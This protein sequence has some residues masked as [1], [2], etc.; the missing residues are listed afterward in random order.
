MAHFQYLAQLGLP[1][2]ITSLVERLIERPV[3]ALVEMLLI[4][5]VVYAVLRFLQG[6]RGARLVRAVLIIL[7]VSFMVVWLIAE[8]FG[9]ERINVLYPYFMLGVFLASLVAFQ[10]ELR[11]MLIRLG[12]GGWLQRWIKGASEPIEPIVTAVERLAGKKIGALIAI[13]RNTE[14]GGLIETGVELDAIVSAELIENIFQPS[15]PLHDL[16]MIIH[17]GR[18]RAAGCQ[19]PLAETGDLDRSLGS[20]H[21]A[22][23]GMSAE[24]DAVVIVVSEETGTISIAVDGRLRRALTHETL[25]DLLDAELAVSPR[26][27]RRVREG[28]LAPATPIAKRNNLHRKGNRQ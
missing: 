6:T 11:R 17:N 14:L 8:R 19:F 28:I 21:R 4:G 7:A 22:A 10:T 23:V 26:G 3:A 25:R 16:G 27:A 13:E 5:V 15:A 24:V 2:G 9:F 1:E 12:Q 20:R 18:I